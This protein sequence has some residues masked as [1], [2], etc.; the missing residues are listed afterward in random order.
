M[1]NE[2]PPSAQPASDLPAGL[3]NP[4][5]RALSA[6]QIITL[7]QVAAHSAAEILQLHGVG[8][9]TIRQLRAALAT[10]GLAFAGEAPTN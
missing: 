3:S 6:A 2:Q 1:P 10:Q 7:T 9:K 8:P 5:Q 4:A